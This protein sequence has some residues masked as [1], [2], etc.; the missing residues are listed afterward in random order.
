MVIDTLATYGQAVSYTVTAAGAYWWY[1]KRFPPP[2]RQ[3]WRDLCQHIRIQGQ[4]G[5]GK[6]TLILNL[7]AE[8]VRAGRTVIVL[9]PHGPLARA[10]YRLD[11]SGLYHRPAQKAHGMNILHLATKREA[12]KELVVDSTL[13]LVRSLTSQWGSIQDATMEK[14]LWEALDVPDATLHDVIERVPDD[15]RGTVA[16]LGKL[17]S[18]PT[19][20][21]MMTQPPIDLMGRSYFLDL[22]GCGERTADVIYQLH[23]IRV[24]QLAMRRNERSKGVLLCCDEAQ[25]VAKSADSLARILAELRKYSVAVCLAHH[26]DVQLPDTITKMYGLIGTQ[27]L[28][29]LTSE[30]ARK[31]KDIIAP[32]P[33]EKLTSLPNYTCIRR[34]QAGGYPEKA[35]VY[36]TPPPP[37]GDDRHVTTTNTRRSVTSVPG[38]SSSRNDEST[39]KDVFPVIQ[40]DSE[41]HSGSGAGRS[42][43]EAPSPSRRKMGVRVLSLDGGEKTGSKDA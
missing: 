8:Q 28:F 33:W 17:I 1:R 3:T 32:L 10:A 5:A 42:I 18:T 41:T 24:Q 30:D 19:L 15:D 2:R 23:M 38:Q 36:R 39:A 35:H 43:S 13:S 27:Y 14:A 40:S 7:I 22:S 4:P 20:R 11:P 6:S 26:S 9:D 25:R 31:A 21:R 37:K 12:E 29:R 34:R 16:R